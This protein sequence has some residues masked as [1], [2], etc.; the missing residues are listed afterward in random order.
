MMNTVSR[1]TWRTQLNEV[2]YA[3][4][5]RLYLYPIPL[6]ASM[7]IKSVFVGLL[8]L[9]NVPQVTLASELQPPSVDLSVL[10]L[11]AMATALDRFR[12]D[13]YMVDDYLAQIVSGKDDI[14]VIFVPELVKS[15]NLLG[16]EKSHKPE[17]HYYLDSTG[18]KVTNVLFGQ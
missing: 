11:R 15:D 6:V 14:K 5:R 18:M 13:G 9:L 4:D 8:L 7:I 12:S 3:I 1:A 16:V 17:V 2:V 10:Q